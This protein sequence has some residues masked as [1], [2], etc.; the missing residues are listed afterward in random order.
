MIQVITET[1]T[2]VWFKWND[3]F[4]KKQNSYPAKLMEPVSKTK[5]FSKFKRDL[6]SWLKSKVF[7]GTVGFW[8]SFSGS[9]QR[10][11][12]V[13]PGW[14]TVAQP[15]DCQGRGLMA[16]HCRMAHQVVY[17]WTRDLGASRFRNWDNTCFETL[18]IC[19]DMH[20]GFN[21]LPNPDPKKMFHRSFLNSSIT[22]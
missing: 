8:L 9:L 12:G 16:C 14:Q 2:M 19:F 20:F 22:V 18:L 7:A 1:G 21:K 4:G 15:S 5:L 13:L 11:G 17:L 10:F 6:S 3:L